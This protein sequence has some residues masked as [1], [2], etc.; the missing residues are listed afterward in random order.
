MAERMAMF[1]GYTDTWPRSGGPYLARVIAHSTAE[2]VV[3]MA[4]LL[5]VHADEIPWHE[6][7]REP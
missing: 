6:L 1:A 5:G 4:M 7:L 2:A 3:R